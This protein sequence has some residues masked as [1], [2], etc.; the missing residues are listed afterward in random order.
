MELSYDENIRLQIDNELDGFYDFVEIGRIGDYRIV[1]R[2]SK[3]YKG[4]ID[5]YDNIIVPLIY[6]SIINVGEYIETKITIDNE[7]F[8][9]VISKESMRIIL[10]AIYKFINVQKNRNVIS[11][12]NGNTWDLVSFKDN[13]IK[14]LSKNTLPFDHDE[15]TCVLLKCSENNY[16]IE[17]WNENENHS[18][19]NL[20]K[21]AVESCCAGRIKLTNKY[22]K[23]VVYTD[24][25]GQ[26][27]FAN[28][29]LSL[30]FL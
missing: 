18:Q 9:G 29:D 22:F 27:L 6:D 30:V 25:Y 23:L 8:V 19:H 28:K 24:I 26:I 13:K 5:E 10:P 16:K 17:C 21:M 14:H 4:L 1:Q 12:Y 2:E 20:R 15:F 11:C 3:T 7:D